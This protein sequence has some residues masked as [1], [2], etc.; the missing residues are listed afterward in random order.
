MFQLNQILTLADGASPN[1][2]SPC[3]DGYIVSLS[4]P[5]SSFLSHSC[6]VCAI[7]SAN[8]ETRFHTPDLIFEDDDM[9]YLFI[10]DQFSFYTNVKMAFHSFKIPFFWLE[11]VIH[12]WITRK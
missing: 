5:H 1:F 10:F 4:L 11:N 7:F 6:Y 12:V 2:S 8:G 9:I 3:K